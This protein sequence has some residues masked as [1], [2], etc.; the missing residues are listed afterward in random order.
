MQLTWENKLGYL[1]VIGP[2]YLF[3]C[4]REANTLIAPPS[5]FMHV[6]VE[7]WIQLFNYSTIASTIQLFNYLREGRGRSWK[8]R[9][10][11]G[12]S[13][14]RWRRYGDEAGKRKKEETSMCNFSPIIPLQDLEG[15][16]DGGITHDRLSFFS[17]SLL[18]PRTPLTHQDLEGERSGGI[19]HARL[20]FFPLPC[21]IHLH[22][23]PHI[24]LTPSPF[25]ISPYFHLNSWS[26]SWIQLS[27]WHYCHI[28]T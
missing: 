9:V 24:L 7:S 17:S 20:F 4:F 28:L 26:N 21:F 25:K 12:E 19:I 13:G 10:W 23:P 14:V 6:K 18:H 1:F 8:V 2:Q 16:G 3:S 11:C 22:P 5:Y 27:T 15:E